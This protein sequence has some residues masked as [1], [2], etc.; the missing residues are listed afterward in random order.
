MLGL[1]ANSPALSAMVRTT[2]TLMRLPAGSGRHLHGAH[3]LDDD[4]FDEAAGV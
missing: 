2:P 1:P 4:D 3:E